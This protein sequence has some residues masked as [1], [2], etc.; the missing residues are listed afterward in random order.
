MIVLIYQSQKRERERKG[1]KREKV[2][3]RRM[4]GANEREARLREGTVK[5]WRMCTRHHQ[6]GLDSAKTCFLGS[7]SLYHRRRA[8]AMY[9]R[10]VAR[11]ARRENLADYS[12]DY[13][14]WETNDRASLNSRS[15][16]ESI[17]NVHACAFMQIGAQVL[18]SRSCGTS[19]RGGVERILTLRSI[20]CLS[21]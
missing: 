11:W 9:R 15:L 12:S 2:L 7:I 4:R 5:L 17:T 16:I 6:G 3:F 21:Y 10:T 13:S 19:S 20:T 18:I 1:G 8:S 14:S